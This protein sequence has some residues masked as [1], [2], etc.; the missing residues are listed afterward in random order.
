M[1]ISPIRTLLPLAAFGA[2]AACGGEPAPEAGDFAAACNA[3][4]NLDP[5][6]CAC[7]DEQ[8]ADL[9]PDTHRFVIATIAEDEEEAQ[10]LRAELDEVEATQAAQFI[11]RGIQSCII[12]IPETDMAADSPQ[13]AMP[14]EDAPAA[15]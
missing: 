11:S 3:S 9:A 14:A 6:L 15:E 8:A 4:G 12:D 13:D 2:L 10:R 5:E 7:L 1:R